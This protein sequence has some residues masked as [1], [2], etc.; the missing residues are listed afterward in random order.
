MYYLIETEIQQK[1]VPR[2]VFGSLRTEED[3]D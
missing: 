1:M 2:E 3:D